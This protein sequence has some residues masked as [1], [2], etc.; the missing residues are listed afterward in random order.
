MSTQAHTLAAA[1]LDA[2]DRCNWPAL[3]ALLTEDTVY[4]CPGLPRCDGRDAVLAYYRHERPVVRGHHTVETVIA[5]GDRA[6]CCGRFDGELRDGRRVHVGFANVVTVQGGRIRAR[7]L[8][9]H[10]PWAA[11]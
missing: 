11:A 8:Y 1:L 6:V 3:A 2:I 10:Q 9:F 7:R 5:D 4:E